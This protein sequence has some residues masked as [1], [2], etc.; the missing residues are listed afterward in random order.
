MAISM[1]AY[2]CSCTPWSSAVARY[3]GNWASVRATLV[4]QQDTA[5]Q[6]A[7]RLDSARGL[8]ASRAGSA[9]P[10]ALGGVAMM[11]GPQPWPRREQAAVPLTGTGMAST[12][13][14]AAVG[15]FTP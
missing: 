9:H 2:W 12:A 3:A 6:G 4:G 13:P 7:R 10:C 8:A 11:P 15:L 14:E 1:S 5:Y